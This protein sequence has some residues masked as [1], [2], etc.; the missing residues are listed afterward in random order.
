MTHPLAPILT[1][2]PRAIAN[3]GVDCLVIGSGTSGVTAAIELADHGLRVA[4]IEAGPLL[5]T[6]HVGSGPFANREDIVPGIHDVVRYGTL[7]TTSDQAPAARAGSLETNNNAW[8]LVGGRTVF[9][10]GC[11]PRFRDEDFASWPYGADEVHPWYKRL[12]NSL[13]RRASAAT[14]ARRWSATPPRIA[15]WHASASTAFLQLKYRWASTPARCETAACRSAST[16]LCHACCATQSLA[17]SR[18]V[19]PCRWPPTPRPS[20]SISNR[21]RC[22]R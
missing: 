7:W 4:I 13:A 15:F 10:G 17:A 20:A 16:P 22:V 11:T 12:S 8:S 19:P 9:W 3:A 14:I 18:T 21:A 5:L 1:S 2:D 6:E